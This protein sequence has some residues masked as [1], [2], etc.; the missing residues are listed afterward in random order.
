MKIFN[1]VI[2]M[3]LLSSNLFAQ[4]SDELLLKSY[5]QDELSIIKNSDNEKYELLLNS[6]DKA[7]VLMD[8]PKDKASKFNGEITLPNGPYTF[9][10]LG[11]KISDTNQY[12]KVTGTNKMLMVKSFYILKSERNEK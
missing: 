3:A 1:T 8:C 12:F 7:L 4:S 6:I 5:T 2:V 9:V 10:D 11:L